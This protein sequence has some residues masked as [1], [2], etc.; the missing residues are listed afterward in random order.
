MTQQTQAQ[1]ILSIVQADV[2]QLAPLTRLFDAYRV[3]YGQESNTP[4]ANHFLF[5]RLINHESVIYM[6]YL[7]DRPVGFAQ[8]YPSFS[9]VSMMPVWV[10]ND[11]YVAEDARRQGIGKA[12]IARCQQLVQ[13]R[14]DKGLLLSTAVTNQAAQALYTKL[15]FK[16]DSDFQHYE[17]LL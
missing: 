8:L 17:W 13:E 14:Q 9:S 2:E 6:A 16:S 15:G 3:F 10:L 12:L 1:Q 5:E 7:K 11:L 4:A